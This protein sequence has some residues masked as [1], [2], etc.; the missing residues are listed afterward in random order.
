VFQAVLPLHEC[1]NPATAE[2]LAK[3]LHSITDSVVVDS[4]VVG[5]ALIETS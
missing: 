5:V 1:A 3:P 2:S 4:T